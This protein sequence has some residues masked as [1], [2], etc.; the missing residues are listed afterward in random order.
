MAYTSQIRVWWGSRFKKGYDQKITFLDREGAKA[1]ELTLPAWRALEAAL[2][3]NGYGSASIVSTYYPRLI[4]GT[5]EWSL[6]SYSGVAIDIDPYSL[7]NPYVKGT[8]WDFS[9]CKFTRAQVDAAL[10]VRT[11]NGYRVWRWGGDFGDYMHW[12]L[13]CRMEDLAT[14]INWA[15]V[16]DNDYEGEDLNMGLKDGDEGRTVQAAQE[17]LLV[18]D[19]DALPMWGAD[20]DFGSETE[21]WFQRFQAS[22]D[23]IETGSLDVA[24]SF[25]LGSY[26]EGAI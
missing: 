3:A 5:N 16:P 18:W 13:D 26:I 15:T 24:T 22:H 10:R 11:T 25:A 23:L 17:A 4:A 2:R 9:L 12:Q 8:R 21:E 14:G 6:H 1:D 20:G 7:G 19:G